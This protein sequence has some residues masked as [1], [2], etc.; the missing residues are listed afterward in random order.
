MIEVLMVIVGLAGGIGIGY[1]VRKAIS[2]ARAGAVELRARELMAEAERDAVSVKSQA[3]VDAK[4]EAIRI[5]QEAEGEVR[6][7]TAEVAR[8]ESRLN[9]KEETLD[10][11]SRRLE[12]RERSL[13][14]R[15][16]EAD[17][18]RSQL[19]ETLAKQQGELERL[20]GMTGQEAKDTLIRQIQDEAKREAMV[21]VRDIEG[22]A[23]EEAE[24][25]ARKIVAIAMQ[26][27][28]SEETSENAISV[29][30]LPND[31]MKGRIIGREGRNIRAFEAATGTNLIIDET[32]ESVVLSCFDPIRRETARLTLEKLI[33]DGRIQPSRIEEVYEKS[34]VEV[35]RAIREAGEW[36]LLDVGITDMHPEMVKVLGRLNYRTSY[37][38]NILKHLVEAAHIAGVIA[39]ELGT[40]IDLAKR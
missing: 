38:Q 1:L 12:G 32:P 20:A 2:E 13:L 39:A 31:E 28:A 7:R 29:V 8:R 6:V 21:L 4:D 23:R 10:E 18:M 19:Q 36:A 16:D 30:T 24:R 22:H 27:I 3:L 11:M 15:A 14:D 34:K 25:R 40:D 5:R 37:G 17:R 9:Q 33:A 35:E 26:R